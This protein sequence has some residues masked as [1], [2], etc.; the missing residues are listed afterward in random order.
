MARHDT[1][2]LATPRISGSGNN[3]RGMSLVFNHSIGAHV[4]IQKIRYEIY[5][6]TN[7]TKKILLREQRASPCILEYVC[8]RP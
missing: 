7:S 4:T 8:Q 5:G 1:L 2:R 3:V 6:S